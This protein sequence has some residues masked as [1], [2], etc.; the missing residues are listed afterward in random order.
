MDPDGDNLR[1]LTRNDALDW[2]PDWQPWGI[3]FMSARADGSEAFLMRS[4]GSDVRQLTNWE[5]GDVWLPTWS[6]TGDVIAV[7]ARIHGDNNDDLY[8]L[9][10]ADGSMINVTQS[11]G[12][13]YGFEW[14]PDGARLLFSSDPD[15]QEDIYVM[16]RDGS[17]LTRLTD[18]PADDVFATWSPDGDR[19]A[20][21]RTTGAIG[22]DVFVMHA[23]GTQPLNVTA[24]QTYDGGPSWSPDGQWLAFERSEHAVGPFELWL[25]RSDGTDAQRLTAG[26]DD[27]GPVWQPRCP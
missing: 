18:D 24:S 3:V 26:W 5:N 22:G 7:G 13:E 15:G 27:R 14:S 11:P 19:I 21:V 4:D 23:D 1:N 16:R 9:D 8:L 12:D 17:D 10:Q 20:W 25:I 2:S 6:P